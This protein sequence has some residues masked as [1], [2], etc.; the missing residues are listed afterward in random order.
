MKRTFALFAAL[1]AAAALPAAAQAGVRLKVD[2]GLGGLG[3]GVAAAHHGPAPVQMAQN[4]RR[5]PLPQV[6]ARLKSQTGGEYVSANVMEQGGRTVYW[7]RMRHP[8]GR[9]VDYVVD[10]QTGQI[11]S[12]QGG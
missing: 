3:I 9:F 4:E 2:A 12:E 7:I 6:I 10:A 5:I 8:G 11:I 1:V